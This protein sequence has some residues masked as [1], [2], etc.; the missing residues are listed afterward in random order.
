MSTVGQIERET[1][2]LKFEIDEALKQEALGR[3][4][5]GKAKQAKPKKG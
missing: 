1:R 5:P 2:Y 3:R 4:K